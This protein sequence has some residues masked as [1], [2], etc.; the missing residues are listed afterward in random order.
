MDAEKQYQKNFPTNQEIFDLSPQ[1]SHFYAH[2]RER[3][4]NHT[5]FKYDSVREIPS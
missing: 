3:L 1:C 2:A 4:S 5:L